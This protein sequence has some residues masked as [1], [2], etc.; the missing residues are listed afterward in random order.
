MEHQNARFPEMPLKQIERPRTIP[1]KPQIASSLRWTRKPRARYSLLTVVAEALCHLLYPIKWQHV[2]IPVLPYALVDIVD[3]PTP[4]LMG[5]HSGVHTGDMHL[6]GV[7]VVDLD[8]NQVH[9]LE[10]L[11]GLDVLS[12]TTIWGV[13]VIC[14]FEILMVESCFSDSRGLRRCP[15]RGP[16]VRGLGFWN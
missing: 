16:Q 13:L 1:M 5:L 11:L 6:D 15:R 8:Q 10:I 3:A 9:G 12:L 7:V 4:Y 2:Y 14:A